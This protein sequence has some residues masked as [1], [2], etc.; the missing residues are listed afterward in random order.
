MP[1]SRIEISLDQ[2]GMLLTFFV[3]DKFDI[4]RLLPLPPSDWQ[5]F[6]QDWFCGC[7]ETH[8]TQPENANTG[9][10][11]DTSNTGSCKSNSNGGCCDTHQ[12]SIK[13]K[14]DDSSKTLLF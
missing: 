4:Q 6:S 2:S 7:C 5:D 9:N 8:D 14:R 1:T 11:R 10:G 13:G 12:L 3:G